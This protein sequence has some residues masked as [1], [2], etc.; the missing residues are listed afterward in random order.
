[1]LVCLWAIILLDNRECCFAFMYCCDDPDSLQTAKKKLFKGR[2][3]HW[4]GLHVTAYI[5]VFVEFKQGSKKH[6]VPSS[7]RY[8]RA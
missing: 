6:F 2:K 4:N 5:L 7:V 3:A 1:M 8:N